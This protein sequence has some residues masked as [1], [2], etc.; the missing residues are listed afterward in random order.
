MPVNDHYDVT[1][2]LH[3]KTNFTMDL[4]NQSAPS[5]SATTHSCPDA[6]TDN[7]AQY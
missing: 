2:V 1:L 3:P 4:K 5:D 6:T 7:L